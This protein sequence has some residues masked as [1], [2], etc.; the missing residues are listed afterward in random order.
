MRT[1]NARIYLETYERLYRQAQRLTQQ[2]AEIEARLSSIG[3]IRYDQD[4]IISSPGDRM[5]DMV[6]RKVNLEQVRSATIY[7]MTGLKADLKQI[8]DRLVDRDR[9]IAEL[10]WFDFEGSV[11][12]SQAVGCSRQTVFRRQ[13]A[14][15]DI[16]QSLLD[17]ATLT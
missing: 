6:A 12:I 1:V 7:E 4:K 10:T 13:R 9:K 5:S 15:V 16:V 3:A 8:F 14:I 2:I 11:Y 17:S